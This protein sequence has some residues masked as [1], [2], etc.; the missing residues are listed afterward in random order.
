MSSPEDATEQQLP[1]DAILLVVDDDPRIRRTLRRLLEV[2]RT[3]VVEAAD[4]EHAIQIVAR[5]EAHLI[6]AVV[7][8][9]AMPVVSGLE[10]IAVLQE[11]R[12]ELPVLAV[13]AWMEAPPGQVDV[14][15]LAKPFSADELL[16]T[17]TPMVR[18][19]RDLRR[20]SRRMRADAAESRS[21][22][23]HHLASAREQHASAQQMLATLVQLREK[24]GRP[25]S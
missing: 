24:L 20:R 23:S 13:S 21:L 9:L 25:R 16:R 7:T 5:D 14:P 3:Q 1:D 2:G 8:D 6:D 15:F 19:A 18:Q 17:L 11:C 10:L 12:P 4:G 22:A